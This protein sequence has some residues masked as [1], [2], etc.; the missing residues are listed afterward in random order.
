[1][2]LGSFPIVGK[3]SLRAVRPSRQHVKELNYY[4]E[5]AVRVAITG[6]R[7]PAVQVLR[8]AVAQAS[9]PAAV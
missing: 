9:L 3:F 8:Q 1:L 7:R 2:D 4:L 6:R 5:A